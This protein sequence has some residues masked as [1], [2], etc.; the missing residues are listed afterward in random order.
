MNYKIINQSL[1]L[2]DNYGNIGRLISNT[3]NFATFDETNKVFLITNVDGK[4]ETK[5][6]NGNNIRVI[7]HE[8][9]EARFSGTDILI[10]KRDGKNV[11][12][13]KIGNV[14]RYY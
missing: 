9:L 11:L 14:K 10:R 13:D 7:A 12:V 6:I 5:D 3:V 2:S 4:L 8:V 1:Y